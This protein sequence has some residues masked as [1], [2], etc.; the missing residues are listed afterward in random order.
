MVPLIAAGA[1]LQALGGIY[2]SYQ[3]GKAQKAQLA[4]NQQAQGALTDSYG[5]A[6][7]YFEPYQLAGQQGLN[8]LMG[9]QAPGQYQSAEQQP[10]WNPQEFNYQQDPGMAYRMKTGQEAVQSGAAASGAGLSGA[11]LKALGKY[12][13]QLGS[14]EYGNAFNRYMQGRQ[15]GYTEH[16]G[17]LGQFNA[18]RTFGA[19]QQQQQY[20]NQ[21][22]LAGSLADYGQNAATNLGSLA[23]NYGSNL[24]GIYGQRGDIQAAGAKGQGEIFNQTLGNIGSGASNALLMN[25]YMSK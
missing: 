12:G 15:Q 18:N 6:Q 3:Q 24:A 16:A 17:A 2:N 19:G 5:N 9:M 20:A 1:G 11:T 22:G 23:S 10:G 25:K 8:Q 7:K 13:Q 14:Q 21:L 4:A